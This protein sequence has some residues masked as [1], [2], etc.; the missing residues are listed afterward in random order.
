MQVAQ[1]SL[2]RSFTF[3]AGNSKVC[4]AVPQ[5]DCACLIESKNITS[6]D[7]STARPDIAITFL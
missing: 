4:F 1:R 5:R 3:R 7:A 2:I 6:P